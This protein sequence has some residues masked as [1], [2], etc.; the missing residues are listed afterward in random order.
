MPLLCIVVEENK[1]RENEKCKREREKKKLDGNNTLAQQSRCRTPRSSSHQA[2]S[3][4]FTRHVA[5]WYQNR[6]Q[7]ATAPAQTAAPASAT[8]DVVAVVVVAVAVVVAADMTVAG[9]GRLLLLRR[10]RSEF[11]MRVRRGRGRRWCGYREPV[12]L[13]D[14]RRLR[15]GSRSNGHMRGVVTQVGLRPLHGDFDGV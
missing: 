6:C 15:G 8:S 5:R 12:P 14:I 4:A 13:S 1:R 10:R 7:T 2:D 9:Q 3:P 11:K